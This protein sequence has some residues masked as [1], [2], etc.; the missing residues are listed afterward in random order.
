M[1]DAQIKA[2]NEEATK[3]YRVI[4]IKKGFVFMSSVVKFPDSLIRIAPDGTIKEMTERTHLDQQ[5]MRIL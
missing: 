1:T 5:Y 3:E 2:V 4:F